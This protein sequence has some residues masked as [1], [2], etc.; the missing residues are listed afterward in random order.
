VRVVNRERARCHVRGGGA[1][2]AKP[3]LRGWGAVG[4]EA[5]VVGPVALPSST[6]PIAHEV[7]MVRS[8]AA[9]PGQRGR[10]RDVI[11]VGAS[12]ST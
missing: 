1:Q 5:D 4:S 8:A 11:A 9:I 2:T 6:A 10:S 3:Q 12:L 7:Q